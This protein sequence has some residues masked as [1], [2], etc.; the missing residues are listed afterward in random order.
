[1]AYILAVD[2]EPEVLGTLSRA[3]RREGYEV[4][5]AQ[6]ASEAIQKISARR[7]D[8]LILDIAMPGMDGL[9]L[10]RQL[11]ADPRYVDLLILF[12]TAHTQTDDVIAGLDAGGDDYVTKPFELTELNARVRALLRRA[13]RTE[14]ERA[15]IELGNVRLDS[16][17]YQVSFNGKTIQLTATE[18]RLLRYLMEHPNRALSPAHLLEAVWDYPANTGDPDLVRAHIRNLR[19]KLGDEADAS[20]FIRTIHGVGYMVSPLT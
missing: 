8:L 18:H 12:L 4:G 14:A 19:A 13:Q 11:R 10:C 17:T 16:S 6:S 1:M 3:L 9:T 15:I 2:D 7:P 5:Q 20:R